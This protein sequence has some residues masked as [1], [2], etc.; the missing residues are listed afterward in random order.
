MRKINRLLNVKFLARSSAIAGKLRSMLFKSIK[1]Y[2]N[3]K[4][5]PQKNVL[6]VHLIINF[7]ILSCAILTVNDLEQT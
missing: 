7:F 3:V 5:A 4:V 2:E 6:F 1:C